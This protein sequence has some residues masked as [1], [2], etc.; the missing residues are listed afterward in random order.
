MCLYQ[1]IHYPYIVITTRE[2][3]N[4]MNNVYNDPKYRNI[5][6]NLTNEL[7]DLRRKYKDSEDL[8]NSFLYN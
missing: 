1:F 6:E 2:K 8:D 7:Y 5:V 4:E 3:K